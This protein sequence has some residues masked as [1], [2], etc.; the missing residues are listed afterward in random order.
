MEQEDPNLLS[1]DQLLKEL[2][3]RFDLYRLGKRIPDQQIFETG[4]VTR[5]A[6]ANFKKGRNISFLNFIKILRGSDLLPALLQ[7]I[8]PAE[9]FSPLDFVQTSQARLPERIRTHKRKKKKF[10]WGDE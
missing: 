1:N 4:G 8:K 3:R 9:R 2:G 6:L 5:Q 10:K 7:A